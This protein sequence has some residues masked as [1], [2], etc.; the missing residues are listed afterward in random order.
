MM[1]R[2][3]LAILVGLVFAAMPGSGITASLE[4]RDR[5]GFGISAS[6]KS[7]NNGFVRAQIR[8][9]L[10]APEYN[11]SFAPNSNFLDSWLERAGKWLGRVLRLGGGV[12]RTASAILAWAV[13][14]AFVFGFAALAFRFAARSRARQALDGFAPTDG[15]DLPSSSRLMAEAARLAEADDYRGAFLRAYLGSISYLDE[16]KALRFERS[17]TNWEYLRE[18]GSRGRQDLADE[19]RPLTQDFDRKL[20][21][22]DI[23]TRRDYDRAVAT[24]D[25][26]RRMAA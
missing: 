1:R 19:L 8:D 22:H 21:G 24:Y 11:R 2:A 20:Y 5:S 4:S 18:L 25:L 10:S 12:G 16:A 3:A 7:R 17:R 14:A 13:I 6:L 9:I 23:S 26:V 15:Y